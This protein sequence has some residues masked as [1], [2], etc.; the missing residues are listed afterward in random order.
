VA[1]VLVA[2]LV[3]TAQ[4]RALAPFV[5]VTWRR[6][7]TGVVALNVVFWCAWYQPWIDPNI[8]FLLGSVVLGSWIWVGNLPTRGHR[9][10]AVAALMS[11]PFASF[12]GVS[13]FV[14][15]LMLLKIPLAIETS[16]IQHAAF[17]IT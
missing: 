3:G 4:R 7:V 8:R 1:L 10:A 11:F 15:A 5:S 9:V 14:M 17:F 16:D 13:C 12:V 6:V 2:V